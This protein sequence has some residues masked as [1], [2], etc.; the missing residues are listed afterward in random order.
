MAEAPFVFIQVRNRG[1]LLLQAAIALA[2]G[3]DVRLLLTAEIY[4]EVQVGQPLLWLVAPGR[5]HIL[6]PCI[7][8][9][10][11]HF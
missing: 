3:K 8:G 9:R 5:A 7:P 2:D 6:E 1:L 10:S 4:V 11:G